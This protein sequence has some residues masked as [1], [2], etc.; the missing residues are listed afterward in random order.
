MSNHQRTPEFTRPLHLLISLVA[1]LAI[2]FASNFFDVESRIINRANLWDMAGRSYKTLLSDLNLPAKVGALFITGTPDHIEKMEKYFKNLDFGDLFTYQVGSLLGIEIT[3]ISQAAFISYVF[4][5]TALLFSLLTGFFI[6]KNAYASVI[7]FIPIAILRNFSQ[8]LIYGLPNKYSFATFNPFL[9]FS[10]FIAIILYLKHPAK[11]YLPV[12]IL[13]GFILAYLEF[14]RTSEGMIIKA[15]ILLFMATMYFKNLTCK[16]QFKKTLFWL[17]LAFTATLAGY[18]GYYKMVSVF[19]THRDNKLNS[20]EAKTLSNQS[21]I[22]FHNLYISLFRFKPIHF[23]DRLAIDATYEAYPELKAHYGNNYQ[24]LLWSAEYS[25]GIKKLY[26]EYVFKH[27]VEFFEYLYKGIYDYFLFLP[28]YSWSGIKSAHAYMPHI[29]EQVEIDP[30]DI[31]PDFLHLSWPVNLKFEYLPQSP[32]FR[33]Y[34]AMSYFFL[35]QA[36]YT[37]FTRTGKNE[38]N[39]L[40]I[41]LLRGMLIYFFFAS[42]VRVLI[43]NYGH[44]A[45]IAFNIIIF[46]NLARTSLALPRM[47]ELPEIKLT[48]MSLSIVLLALFLILKS[49]NWPRIP[50]GNLIAN[51]EFS[52]NNLEG[53]SPIWS[54]MFIDKKGLSGNCLKIVAPFAGTPSN[55]FY[56]FPTNNGH[57]YLMTVYFK[58]G[59]NAA[60]RIKIGSLGQSGDLYDSG[61]L[62]D[63]DWRRYDRIF[64]ASSS[65]SHITLANDGEMQGRNSYFDAISIT[66]IE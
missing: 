10:F 23:G 37:A 38:E 26:I 30:R 11:K 3:E 63:S 47:I 4:G 61:M 62:T 5:A 49:S 18:V 42:A 60:G 1:T 65:L 35:F 19:E 29:N 8:G 33:I 46:Y 52:N 12:F 6:F 20:I 51:G 59:D 64:L 34:F 58:K 66:E 50:K 36:V 31:D 15:S 45:V 7:L 48:A 28:Y 56:I 25:D 54:K 27:P 21:H 53:W 43:A 32:L 41:Y 14:C 22:V 39:P 57:K 16:N 40:P 13:S 24:E 44:S 17:L 9:V 55:S 2:S